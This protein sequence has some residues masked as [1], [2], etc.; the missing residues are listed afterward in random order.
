MESRGNMTMAMFELFTS[1][2][3]LLYAIITVWPLTQCEDD[4]TALIRA[5]L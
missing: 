2:V 1:G 5:S 3:L 4:N